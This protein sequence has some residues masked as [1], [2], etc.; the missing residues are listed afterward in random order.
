MWA[1]SS[2]KDLRNFPWKK[3][4]EHVQRSEAAHAFFPKQSGTGYQITEGFLTEQEHSSVMDAFRRERGSLNKQPQTMLDLGDIRQK[5]N[6]AVVE[7]IGISDLEGQIK[8]NTFLQRVDN[9]P[10]DNDIQKHLHMDTFFP[11]WKFWYFPEEVQR[12]QGTFCFVPGSH[13]LNDKKK[14]WMLEQYRKYYSGEELNEYSRE[15]SLRI[16]EQEAL[17]LYETILEVSVPA[18]TLVI[19]NVFGFHGRGNTVEPHSRIAIHGSIRFDNP[20][21]DRRN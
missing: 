3:P 19:A 16:S 21:I 14:D 10:R 18:N 4:E 2:V 15:G 7:F 9:Y 11:A 17:S 5:I 1:S 12:Y 6:H 13:I 20:F 8:A